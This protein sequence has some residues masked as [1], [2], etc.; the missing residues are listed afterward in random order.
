MFVRLYFESR[1]LYFVRL[2]PSSFLF[3]FESRRLYF[4][5]RPC[6]LKAVPALA[7]SICWRQNRSG[8]FPGCAFFIT[9]F[10]LF[11]L[12]LDLCIVLC[13]VLSDISPELNTGRSGETV[14]A[15]R[16]SP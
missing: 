14:S 8:T 3:D 10:E 5:C 6:I 15:F 13:L 16:Y 12:F 4:E 7:G 11:V 2:I 9:F 1:R